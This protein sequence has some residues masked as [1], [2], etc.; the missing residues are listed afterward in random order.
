MY[1][2]HDFVF[3]NINKADFL[4]AEVVCKGLVKLRWE[5]HKF[6]GKWS[7]AEYWGTQCGPQAGNFS[8][9]WLHYDCFPLDSSKFSVQLNLYLSRLA[10][11]WEQL[12]KDWCRKYPFR[13]F[14]M[15]SGKL[16]RQCNSKNVFF[17][18]CISAMIC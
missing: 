4:S 1:F 5:F 11:N 6:P 15:R 17:W 12:T 10:E 16:L 2:V 7:I 3:M 13:N 18:W 9:N 14:K 8:K